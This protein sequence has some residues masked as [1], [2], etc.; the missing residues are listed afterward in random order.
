MTS[1]LVC[2]ISNST[3]MKKILAIALLFTAATGTAQLKEEVLFLGNSYTGANNLPSLTAQVALSAGDTLI[4]DSNTPGGYRFLNHAADATSVA[5]IMSNDWDHVILQAQ[6]QE[7]SWPDGQV[8]VEVFPYAEI[9][10]DTIRSGA[11]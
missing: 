3:K 2:Y 6:S 4:Y 5:K 9:L 10:C 8:A 7:P 11:Q 1:V